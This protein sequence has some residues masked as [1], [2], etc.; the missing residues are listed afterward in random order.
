[1]IVVGGGIIGSCTA[2]ALA[3]SGKSALLLE[4]F[5]FLHRRGSSHGD[6]RIIRRTYPEDFYAQMMREAYQRWDN[7]EHEAGT[8]VIR[9]VGS[10]D[11]GKAGNQ[12]IAGVREACEKHDI[13]YLPLTPAEV[14][15]RFPGVR[16][17]DGFEAVF[18]GTYRKTY[19]RRL[20]RPLA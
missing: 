16:L 6:S 12:E 8:R 2:Y 1:M 19:N 3:A 7:A 20:C 14:A 9:T 11:F 18:S 4:Q 15:E 10:L 13:E 5:S 17:P